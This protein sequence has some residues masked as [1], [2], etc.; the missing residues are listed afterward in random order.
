MR[1]RTRRLLSRKVSIGGM[2]EFGLWVGL[3]YLVIGMVLAFMHYD[4]VDR[5]EAEL[6]PLLPAGADLVAFGLTAALWPQMLI[7]SLL[8]VT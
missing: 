7:A 4:S 6:T 3:G 1:T 8:C 2:L 5:I